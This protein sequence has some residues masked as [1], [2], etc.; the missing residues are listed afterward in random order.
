MNDRVPTIHIV[1]DDETTRHYFEILVSGEGY[2]CRLIAS[3][4]EFLDIY[5]PSQPGCLLLDVQLPGMS[6]PEL[7]NHLNQLGAVIPVVFI[8]GH[9]NVALAVQAMKAGAFG[10]LEKPVSKEALV[11]QVCAAMQRDAEIR[12]AMRRREQIEQRFGTLTQRERDVLVRVIAGSSNKLMATD[13]NLSQ[14]TVELYRARIMEKTG[15]RSLAQLVRMAIDLGT[16]PAAPRA[17]RP[18]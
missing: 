16:V 10:F 4:Q 8:S 15:S 9:A 13:L 18:H 12:A 14:R 2:P 3:G 11:T 1:D 6:G 17:S 7:Q 5:D